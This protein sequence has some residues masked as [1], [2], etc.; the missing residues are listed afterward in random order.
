MYQCC[1]GPIRVS[2]SQSVMFISNSKIVT[3][4]R[5]QICSFWV[6]LV[7]TLYG[8]SINNTSFS[9]Q[10][11]AAKDERQVFCPDPG[12]VLEVKTYL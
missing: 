3:G 12:T 4:I 7:A 10:A 6:L 11:S 9:Q 8:Y 2:L 1:I 5:Y